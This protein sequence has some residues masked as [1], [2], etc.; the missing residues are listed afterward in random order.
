MPSGGW[1]GMDFGKPVEIGKIMYT[2]RGDGNTIEIGDWYELYYWDT[3]GWV[4]IGKQIA[5]TTYLDFDNVPA[6]ALLLL[7]NHTQGVDERVFL[8]EDDEQR[9]W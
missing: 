1:A 2:P 4:S 7:K 3:N 9:F 5:T 6:G 8:Y